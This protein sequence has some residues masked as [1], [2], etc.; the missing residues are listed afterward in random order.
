MW[1]DGIGVITVVVIMVPRYNTERVV[2]IVSGIDFMVYW[3]MVMFFIG[4][5]YKDI[6]QIVLGGVGVD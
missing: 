6:P 2:C 1:V 5:A 4:V 3:M